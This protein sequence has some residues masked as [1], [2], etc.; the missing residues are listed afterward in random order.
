MFNCIKHDSDYLVTI[1]KLKNNLEIE[2]T[3]K[4]NN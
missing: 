4:I 2:I 3:I 1:I